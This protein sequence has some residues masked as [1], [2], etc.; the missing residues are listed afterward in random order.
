MTRPRKK[1]STGICRIYRDLLERL[2]NTYPQPTLVVHS[3][4]FELH[5]YYWSDE[6]DEDPGDPGHPPFAFCDGTDDTIHISVQ[7]NRNSRENIVW[8][9]LH[10]L[11]HLYALHKYGE[12]DRRWK[13]Y[14][15]AERFANRFASRWVSRLKK[16]RWL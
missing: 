12:E 7:L 15:E 8:Y 6:C 11:G 13:E 2:P 16:E 1:K 3:S 14:K 5:D 10:E 4:L 9:Y